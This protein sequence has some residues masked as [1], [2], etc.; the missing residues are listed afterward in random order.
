VKRAWLLLLGMLPVPRDG[1][2][3]DVPALRRGVEVRARGAGAGAPIMGRLIDLRAD[4]LRI[5]QAE[6]TITDVP[7]RGLVALE[8]KRVS[9]ATGTGALVGGIVGGAAAALFAA[10]F[11]NDPDTLCEADE[12]LRIGLLIGGPPLA[13]GAIIG[14]LIRRERWVAVPVESLRLRLGVGPGGLQLGFRLTR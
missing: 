8:V 2:G 4:A 13:A 9:R 7:R 5:E 14:T 12:Y 11:C 1:E 3:Q 10:G 6:G